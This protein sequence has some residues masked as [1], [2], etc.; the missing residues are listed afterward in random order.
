[1]LELD[2]E[3]PEDDPGNELRKVMNTITP[4][5]VDKKVWNE[6]M[7]TASER[8]IIEDNYIGLENAKRIFQLLIAANGITAQGKGVPEKLRM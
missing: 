7:Y 5:E 2:N 3:Y 6:L 8:G 1:M 4:P